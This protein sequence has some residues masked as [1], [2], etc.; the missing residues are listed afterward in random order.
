MA[1]IV[2]LRLVL[3]RVV[4]VSRTAHTVRVGAGHRGVVEIRVTLPAH[5]IGRCLSRQYLPPA[6]GSPSTGGVGVIVVVVADHRDLRCGLF[7][8]HPSRYPRPTSSAIG[9]QQD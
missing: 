7:A 2:I 9:P 8:V 3:E 6:A 5:L 1:S 4:A